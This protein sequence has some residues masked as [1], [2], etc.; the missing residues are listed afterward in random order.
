MTYLR[1]FT[2]PGGSAA[3]TVVVFPQAGAGCL[4][5]RSIASA[6]PDGLDLL[7]VQLPGREDRLGDAPPASVAEVVECVSDELRDRAP[8]RPLTLLGFSLGATIAYEVARSLEADGAAPDA[9]VV[10]AARSP[11]FWRVFPS[12]DPPTA[13]LT[14]LL[15]PGRDLGPDHYVLTTLRADLRL[16]AGYRVPSAPLTGTRLRTVSGRRDGV[17]TT[18][19]MSGWRDRA[20]DYRGHRVIDAEHHHLMEP[21]VLL[22][23]LSDVAAETALHRAVGR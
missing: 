6:A 11:E 23:L 2:A 7:G 20:A 17:V 18:D 21:D 10:V 5:L 3:S 22:G 12:A 4:R 16:M 13:E 9:L 19:Q 1:S 15:P 8:C 14:A